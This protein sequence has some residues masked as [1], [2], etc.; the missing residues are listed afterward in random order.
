[1]VDKNPRAEDAG[2]SGELELINLE[3]SSTSVVRCS[4]KKMDSNQR[5]ISIL[6]SVSDNSVQ[7][8]HEGSSGSETIR[9]TT[10]PDW[11]GLENT[12]ADIKLPQF[13]GD[14]AKVVLN[15]AP[16]AR[17]SLSSPFRS[18]EDIF[19]VMIEKDT[20]FIR[21]SKNLLS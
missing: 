8:T 10:L 3:Y 14:T 15:K 16:Q 21:R 5:P 17:Y 19:P 4:S 18:E 20:R 11:K 13:Q 6:T 7:L 1:M 9:L 2:R 12:R